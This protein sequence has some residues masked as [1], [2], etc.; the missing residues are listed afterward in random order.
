MVIWEH[1]GYIYRVFSNDRCS[2]MSVL[3]WGFSNDSVSVACL[4][5]L[6]YVS[7]QQWS[8]GLDVTVSIARPFSPP[9]LLVSTCLKMPSKKRSPFADHVTKRNGG[10]GDENV[11]R[12]SR[13]RNCLCSAHARQGENSV[14]Q[15]EENVFLWGLPSPSHLNQLFEICTIYELISASV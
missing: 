4:T 12:H 1:E 10:S 14:W 13:W 7:E 2:Q 15:L 11:A 8:S 9:V 5:L 6:F 3:K